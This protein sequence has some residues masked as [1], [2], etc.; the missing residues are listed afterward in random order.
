MDLPKLLWGV[1][2]IR[3]SIFEG[4]VEKEIK[5]CTFSVSH[6][7]L[8]IT[9]FSLNICGTWVTLSRSSIAYQLQ[10]KEFQG[11]SFRGVRPGFSTFNVILIYTMLLHILRWDLWSRLPGLSCRPTRGPGPRGT[12]REVKQEVPT[13]ECRA[14]PNS[15]SPKHIVNFA[16]SLFGNNPRSFS[17][18]S[19]QG[20][21]AH[22]GASGRPSQHSKCLAMVIS[23]SR[24]H[25]E[26][27]AVLSAG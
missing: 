9:W 16:V 15:Y 25:A 4:R 21:G 24:W 23:H 13:F 22:V 6:W 11:R 18:L 26:Q 3:K 8:V 10:T 19:L 14:M 20:G 17:N 7:S 1:W 12:P 5:T 27:F 2:E